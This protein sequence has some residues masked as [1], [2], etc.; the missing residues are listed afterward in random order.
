MKV[1]VL[2]SGSKGN[3]TLVETNQNKFLIDVG[4]N[5]KNLK[6]RLSEVN[7]SI[8]EIDAIFITHEHTDHIKGLEVLIKRHNI[9]IVLSHGTYQAIVS[10]KKIGVTYEYFNVIETD[11]EVFLNDTRII[12]FRVSHD[13]QEPFGYVIQNTDKKLVYL[14]D[15]GYVSQ[16]NEEKIKD[17]D[18]YIMETNHNIELLMLTNR[19]WS[20]KQRILGDSGHLCNEDALNTLMRVI[21]DKTKVIY[22]AHI[23]EEANNVDLLL[24]TV[25]EIFAECMHQER[26]KFIVAKQYELSESTTL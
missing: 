20:L 11:E 6:N 7:V 22:L 19:P 10:R 21:S 16:E 4:L 12:P 2:A 15:S 25:K 3:C 1:T 5:Y 17:A 23:S 9:Y 14:T 8:D 24:L 13:A 18:I 26:I